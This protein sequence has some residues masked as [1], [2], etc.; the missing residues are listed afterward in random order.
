MTK[1]EKGRFGGKSSPILQARL[2]NTP[3]ATIIGRTFLTE[4]RIQY[5]RI[6]N[7]RLI[8]PFTLSTTFLVRLWASLYKFSPLVGGFNNGVNKNCLKAYPLS[9]TTSNIYLAPS[10]ITLWVDLRITNYLQKSG[11]FLKYSIKTFR[12]KKLPKSRTF[13]LVIFKTP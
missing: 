11:S 12:K 9:P 10:F 6:G 5:T 8:I 1:T 13:T 2:C 7:L 3:A 4:Q